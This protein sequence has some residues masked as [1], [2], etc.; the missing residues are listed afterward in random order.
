MSSGVAAA[1]FD[2]SWSLQ[3]AKMSGDGAIF[4]GAGSGSGSYQFR[5]L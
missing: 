1:V 4:A 2:V 5:G 3:L